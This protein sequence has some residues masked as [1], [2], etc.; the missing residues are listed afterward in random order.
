MHSEALQIVAGERREGGRIMR[1][2]LIYQ[3]WTVGYTE[4]TRA[5]L[6]EDAPSSFVERL[7]ADGYAVTRI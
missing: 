2:E 4:G 6:N 7:I 3:G 1:Q 5:Y